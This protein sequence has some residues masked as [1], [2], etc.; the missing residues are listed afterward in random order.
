MVPCNSRCANENA[1]R[2][3]HRKM[4]ISQHLMFRSCLSEIV[5]FKFQI[6]SIWRVSIWT[7][8]SQRGTF[9]S[10]VL[11]ENASISGKNQKRCEDIAK[12]ISA[13]ANYR[14][15]LS[16][17]RFLFCLP[18]QSNLP[19]CLS[20]KKVWLKGTRQ[21]YFCLLSSLHMGQEL[22]LILGPITKW[23]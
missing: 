17:L 10:I 3:S 20:P 5:W 21:T 2:F 6:I 1:W 9:P 19:D 22:L 14:M 18:R 15:D 16:C 12:E 11:R 7:A 4:F 23:V 8:T 13:A